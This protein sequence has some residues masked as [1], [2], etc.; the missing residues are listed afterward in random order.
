MPATLSKKEDAEKLEKQKR[1]DSV[2]N[3]L[4]R[5]FFL[6]V[7]AACC[8]ITVEPG[9]ISSFYSDVAVGAT[10]ITTLTALSG[11]FEFTLNPT[12]GN[13]SD[14][15]GR[16]PFF[17]Y[18][19]AIVAIMNILVSIYP[20]KNL[21]L[22]NAI[23]RRT[24][25]TFGGS[26]ATMT[27]LGDL[28]QGKQF[29]IAFSKAFGTIGFGVIFGPLCSNVVQQLLGPSPRLVYLMTSMFAMIQLVNNYYNIPE[30]LEDPKDGEEKRTFKGFVNPFA[31][32][33]LFTK[34]VALSK[35][36]TA[37]AMASFT[38]GKNLN[39]LGLLWFTNNCSITPND[40]QNYITI[41]GI[42]CVFSG[43][44]LVPYLIQNLG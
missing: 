43:T 29:S 42:A 22:F 28:C 1:I 8:P 24:M 27:V 25:A 5:S 13:L 2:V 30:T 40:L 31:F 20:V 21:V 3:A 14:V 6:G 17:I 19:P 37:A 35:C 18:P 39:D 16:R 33:K 41:W 11:F 38:E 26:V 15:I 34:S 12:L 44:K 36:V 4:S 32:Y 23:V 10:A 7:S 9:V